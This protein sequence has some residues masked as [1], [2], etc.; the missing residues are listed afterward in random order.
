MLLITTNIEILEVSL[1]NIL[2][3]FF[4]FGLLTDDVIYL[5]SDQTNIIEQD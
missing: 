1:K 4:K 2:F 5:Y 3:V